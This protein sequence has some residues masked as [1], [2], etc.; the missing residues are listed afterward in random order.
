M[1]D[2]DRRASC[3]SASGW[4]AA[5]KQAWQLRVG[6]KDRQDKLH[7]RD[8][9]LR[10]LYLKFEGKQLAYKEDEKFEAPRNTR[11]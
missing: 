11:V 9:G 1:E 6:L 2:I 7:I 4:L 5:S 10:R 3:N 8:V